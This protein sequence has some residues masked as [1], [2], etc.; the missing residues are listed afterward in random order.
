MRKTNN[1]RNLRIKKSHI[2][3][4]LCQFVLL[5]IAAVGQVRVFAILCFAIIAEN[6]FAPP[7]RVAPPSPISMYL[8]FYLP[9]LYD[10]LIKS[11]YYYYPQVS[12][13]LY[14]YVTREEK[15]I[16]FFYFFD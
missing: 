8:Y 6:R 5:L 9:I 15:H 2:T 13:T 1:N 3:Q 7:D 10:K 11:Y 16:L 14:A 12:E 4:L